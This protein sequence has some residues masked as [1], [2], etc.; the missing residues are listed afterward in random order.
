MKTGLWLDPVG[1]TF[2]NEF[3]RPRYGVSSIA[4][5]VSPDKHKYP[6]T[7]SQLGRVAQR[8]LSRDDARESQSLNALP[9]GSRTEVDLC[10]Q[11][12]HRDRAIRL[13]TGQQFA[14][15]PVKVN[16][17]SLY[18]HFAINYRTIFGE[19]TGRIRCINNGGLPWCPL[20]T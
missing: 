12:M 13:Q 8:H 3:H 18:G 16:I 4:M 5:V 15:D 7:P 19:V 20:A 2:S 9:A 11:R 17:I 6:G 1:T 14:V 10:R